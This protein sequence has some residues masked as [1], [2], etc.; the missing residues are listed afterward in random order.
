MLDNDELVS[1]WLDFGQIGSL[2]ALNYL[3]GVKLLAWH[4]VSKL[5]NN[6]RNKDVNCNKPLSEKYELISKFMSVLGYVLT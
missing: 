3:K 1:C 5:V 4:K 2:D 6:S